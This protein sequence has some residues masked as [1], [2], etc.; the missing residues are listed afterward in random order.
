MLDGDITDLVE[1]QSIR[2]AQDYIDIYSISWGPEDDGVTLD[3]PGRLTKQALEL[4]A[5]KVRSFC[6]LINTCTK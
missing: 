5:K 1:S 2:H 4:G 6:K 3:G